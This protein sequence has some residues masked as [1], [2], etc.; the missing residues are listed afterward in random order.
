[1]KMLMFDFRDSEKDFFK[2]NDFQDF[3]ITY[4]CEPLNEMSQLSEKQYEETDVISVFISSTLSEEVLKKFKNLRVIATRSTGFNHIDIKYCSQNNIAVFNVE[5]YGQTSV[6]Q[7]TFALLLAL[8]RNLFPANLDIQRGY[9]NH[10]NYEGRNLNKMTIGIIG[11]GAIGS[12]VAKIAH[13]FN[14]KVLVCSYI[15]RSD[16]S[17]FADYVSMEELLRESDIVTLH[18]PYNTENYHMMGKAEFDMMK[19]G[20]Y[21]INTARGELI[22]V[23]ALYENLINGKLKGAALD[24]LECEYLALSPENLVDDIREDNTNCVASALITQKFL[25]MQNVIITPHIAYNTE[26]SVETLLET[27]F[28]NIRDYYK[29]VRNNQV[30]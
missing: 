22:D 20:S 16:V 9:I 19:E 18:L 17:I 2:R 10:A 4:I 7:F 14:M 25:G 26:E 8:V 3:D 23:V 6:A 1:M 12:M 21:F 29:G 27:T 24:V 11:C 15:K 13:S 28:N 5:E 30:C